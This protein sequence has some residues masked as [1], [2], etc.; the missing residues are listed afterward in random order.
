M[1]GCILIDSKRPQ[2]LKVVT[3]LALLKARFVQYT[4]SLTRADR[5]GIYTTYKFSR[6]NYCRHTLHLATKKDGSGMMAGPS[7]T[8]CIRHT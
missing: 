5:S 6:L 2:L 1:R 7:S 3:L 8:M 4:I